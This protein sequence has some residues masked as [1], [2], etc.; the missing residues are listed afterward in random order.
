MKDFTEVGIEER[1]AIKDVSGG[2]TPLEC[3]W[4]MSVQYEGSAW[5]DYAFPTATINI[6]LPT[7]KLES[8]IYG[9][10]Y[11]GK[12]KMK[13]YGS[14]ELFPVIPDCLKAAMQIQIP[15]VE[16]VIINRPATI[17]FWNDGTKTVC[18][19]SKGD[20]FDAEKGIAMCFM[21]KMF[22]NPSQ[23]RKFM[24]KWIPWMVMSR[25]KQKDVMSNRKAYNGNSTMVK[26]KKCCE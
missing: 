8:A 19:C 12:I 7:R 5:D 24:K 6:E 13:D 4:E 20:T 23:V 21:K 22:G 25:V 9:C 17:V 11:R 18:K 26:G 10:G 3:K 14:H 1:F 15:F 16:N 2:W